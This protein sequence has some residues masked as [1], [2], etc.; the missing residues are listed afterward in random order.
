MK[1]KILIIDDSEVVLGVCQSILEGA[2]YQ[3]VTHARATG[4]VALILQCK[5]DLVLLD[6]NMPSVRGDMVARM[7]SAT[8]PT[9]GTIVLLHSS[10]DE[11]ELK[12]LTEECGAHGYLRKTSNSHAFLRQIATYLPEK[13]STTFRVNTTGAPPSAPESG[14]MPR[15]SGRSKGGVVLLVNGDMA[16]MSQLRRMI[17][18]LGYQ[19][20]F[21]LSAQQGADKL[22]VS[23][24]PCAVIV[25]AELPGQGMNLVFDAAVS[26]DR[27]FRERMIVIASLDSAVGFPVGFAGMVVTRPVQKSALEKVLARSTAAP[28]TRVVER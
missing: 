19:P 20:E 12:R 2:G 4:S 26:R 25:S 10:L 8:R 3:V 9:T 21:A 15:S 13:D 5:P 28:S 14:P 17:Q 22:N 16:E 6:V 23:V 1:R 24:A 18:E 7:S 11:A 27:S